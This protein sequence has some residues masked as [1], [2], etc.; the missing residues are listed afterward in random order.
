MAEVTETTAASSSEGQKPA[1]PETKRLWSDE[2]DDEEVQPSAT[3]EKAVSELNVDALAIDE[4]TKVNKFLDEPED[5]RIQAVLSP[6][7]LSRQFLSDNV[8]IEIE[9]LL[10]YCFIV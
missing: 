5:S 4:N 6:P 2:V 1:V 9:Y 7:P 3:E 8:K 10:S